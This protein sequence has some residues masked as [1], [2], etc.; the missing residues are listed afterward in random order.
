MYV[1]EYIWE[2]VKEGIELH[3]L[4]TICTVHVHVTCTCIKI[5]I[6]TMYMYMYMYNN[7]IQ[8]PVYDVQIK[9]IVLLHYKSKLVYWKVTTSY[10][11][12]TPGTK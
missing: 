12:V 6:V 10:T 2:Q 5:N 7:A 3:V 1:T 4:Y 9:Y 8:S 11:V